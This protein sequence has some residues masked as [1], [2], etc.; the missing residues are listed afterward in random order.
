MHIDVEV[1]R[2]CTGASII[3]CIVVGV[4]ATLSVDDIMP[5]V[6]LAGIMVEGVVCAVVDCEVECVNVGAS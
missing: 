3:V 5:S 4:N 6:L 1:E 2:I